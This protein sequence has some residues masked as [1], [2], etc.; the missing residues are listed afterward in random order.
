MDVKNSKC[1]KLNDV[2]DTIYFFNY[3]VISKSGSGSCKLAVLMKISLTLRKIRLLVLGH[4]LLLVALS[5]IPLFSDTCSSF[6]CL[7]CSYAAK[8]TYFFKYKDT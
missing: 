5:N 8:K 2:V 4:F 7:G 3:V 6:G 1:N